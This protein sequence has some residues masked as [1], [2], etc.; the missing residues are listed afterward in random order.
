MEKYA[1]RAEVNLLTFLQGLRFGPKHRRRRTSLF[2]ER[3][4]R[5]DRRGPTDNGSR[6]HSPG[7]TSSKLADPANQGYRKIL[8]IFLVNPT[9]D[10]VVSA[11]DVPSQQAAWD[12]ATAFEEAYACKGAIQTSRLADS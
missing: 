3:C 8:A 12:A 7:Q 1:L 6:P 10:R 5:S 2:S 9:Q 11:T 4:I